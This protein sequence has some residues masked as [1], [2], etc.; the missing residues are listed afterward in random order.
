MRVAG[1]LMFM[2]FVLGDVSQ[3]AALRAQTDESVAEW[4]RKAADLTKQ[5]KYTEALPILEKLV[6]VEPTN[7][8]THFYLGFALIAQ[9]SV[10]KDTPPSVKSCGL[11]SKS[12]P[13]IK[14]V[15]N[16]EP[17]VDAL[18]RR[19]ARRR[20]GRQGIFAKCGSEHTDD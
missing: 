19:D 7:A 14:G 12:F 20:I 10:T 16:W 18:I 2:I 8:E 11:C 13:Q 4:K 15:R 1:H 5:Q 3:P 6:I 9:G 17:V